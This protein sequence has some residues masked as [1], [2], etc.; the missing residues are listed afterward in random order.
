[1][2]KAVE[3][4]GLQFD[5][6]AIVRT[7]QTLERQRSMRADFVFPASRLS[8]TDG[9]E[10]VLATAG[11]TFRVG[12]RVF[13]EWS[14]AEAAAEVNGER[15]EVC[16][17]PA[18]MPLSHH[19]AGQL[20]STLGV[21]Q[22]FS[23]SPAKEVRRFARSR[24]PRTARPGRSPFLVRTLPNDDGSAGRYCRAFLSDRYRCLDNHDLFLPPPTRQPKR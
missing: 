8:Y 10:L 14:D 5:R 3:Y 4:F 18:P 19:A 6:E 7:M 23:A 13:T 2:V 11:K 15:V 22:V 20:A 12:E 17:S 16:E 21:P 9:G 24:V 1:M